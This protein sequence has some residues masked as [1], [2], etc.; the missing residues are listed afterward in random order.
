MNG[1]QQGMDSELIYNMLQSINEKMINIHSV[2][3]IRHG[4]LVTEAYFDPFDKD[5]KQAIYSCTK[6]VLSALYG[7]AMKEGYIKDVKQKAFDFLKDEWPLNASELRKSITIEHLLTMTSGIKSPSVYQ[8]AIQAHPM[9]YILGMPLIYNPGEG[10]EYNGGTAHLLAG[11]FKQAT[12]VNPLEYAKV[13][14]FTPLGINRVDWDADSKGVSLG[15]TGILF[16]PVEMSKFGYLYL[17]N[18]VWN[19][20]QIVPKEWIKTSTKKYVDTSTMIATDE[21]DGYGYLWWMNSFG[22]YAAHGFGGQY[23][24]VV[25]NSDL[26]VVFTSGLSNNDFSIPKQL[27]ESYIIPAV[28]SGKTL[29]INFMMQKQLAKLLDDIR[30]PEAQPVSSL[31]EISRE[32]SGKTY[33]CEKNSLNWNTFSLNYNSNNECRLILTLSFAPQQ[34]FEIPIGMNNR[35]RYTNQ[36]IIGE[37]YVKGCWLDER[38]YEIMVINSIAKMKIDAVFENGEVMIQVSSGQKFKAK[39]E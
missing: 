26:V 37:C 27:M 14:L 4:Y 6:S 22:G 31:Q 23:I 1:G 18:G 9:N 7:I 12:G 5:T 36:N 30:T 39:Q 11:I 16:T 10:F 32:I 3:I 15:S 29:P 35:Y 28:K 8:V 24:F 33:I 13:K 38:T 25:P 19:G 2:L 17:R 20:K 34:I 21:V